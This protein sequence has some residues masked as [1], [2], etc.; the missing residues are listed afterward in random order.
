MSYQLIFSRAARDDLR[1][2]FDFLLERELSSPT[3]DP[4]L[5]DRAI[6]AIERACQFLTHSPFSCR[7]AIANPFMRELLISFGHS[8]YVA[9]F[10][11]QDERRVIVGAVRHQRESDYH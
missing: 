5:P 9:L 1:R 11:I 3:G 6:E 2:L 4:T 10:E 7:K 8:G